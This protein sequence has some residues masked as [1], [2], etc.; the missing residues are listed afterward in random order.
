MENRK[1]Y[2]NL[3]LSTGKILKGEKIRELV[4]FIVNKFAEENI[5]RDEAYQVLEEVKEVVGEVAIVQ[6]ID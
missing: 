5:S 2:M 6:H 3:A 4:N 1:T